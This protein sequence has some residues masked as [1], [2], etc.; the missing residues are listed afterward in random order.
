MNTYSLL[1]TALLFGVLSFN[2]NIAKTYAPK[3]PKEPNKFACKLDGVTYKAKFV[4]GNHEKIS[5]RLIIT[6][7][8][9]KDSE[10]IQFQM[11]P[12]IVA[13][14]YNTF[15]DMTKK[16]SIYAYYAPPTSEEAGDDGLAQTGSVII[17]EH[18]KTTKRI[19]GTFSFTTAPSVNAG[20]VWK[21][22]DGSFDIS[23]E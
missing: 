13:G 2:L 17:I 20:T 23:Y 11:S 22:T 10:E 8:T 7:S 4:S 19:R 6:A 18:N 14:T 5:N 15:N 3:A 21:I 16:E 9:G 1:F 12:N